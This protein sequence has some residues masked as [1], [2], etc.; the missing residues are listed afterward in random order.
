MREKIPTTCHKRKKPKCAHTMLN[1]MVGSSMLALN[2]SRKSP[3][4][5]PSYTLPS[6]LRVTV[7]SVT[8]ARPPSAPILVTCRPPPTARMPPWGGL[9]MAEKFS[10]PNM[11]RLLTEKLPPTYSSGI[12]AFCLAL[13]AS[14]RTSAE[15]SD[16]DL[17]LASFTIGVYNPPSVA[18]ATHTSTAG[19]GRISP[20]AS[21]Q[22]AFAAGTSCSASAT[23]RSTQSFTEIFVPLAA[24]RLRI[25]STLSREISMLAYM[26]GTVVLDSSNRLAIT[27]R[28]FVVGMSTNSGAATESPPSASACVC[29]VP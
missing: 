28:M 7:I 29:C 25:D 11:P 8:L 22:Y 15:I 6:A 4:V 17:R 14:R 20:A 21:S 5:C 10:T 27:L 1:R 26:C 3:A 16:S 23:A 9:M 12:R 24:R 18:T 19:D 2:A 13:P